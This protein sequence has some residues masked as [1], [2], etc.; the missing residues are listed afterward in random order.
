M[1]KISEMRE[2]KFLKKED[3][4]NG[5]KFTIEDCRQ[6]NVAKEGADPDLKWCLMFHGQDKPM[7]LNTTNA[8]IC[9]KVFKSEES[10]D[11]KGK[12]IVLF[13][14]PNVTYAGKLVGG[15]RVRAPKNGK[16]APAPPPPPV[17][18]EYDDEE[19]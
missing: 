11:W 7:V 17:Q 13:T 15:I 5:V 14:D 9:A 4:G 18:S 6:F 19:L 2:S 8:Q 3:V 1:P 16:P 12:Q 10:D